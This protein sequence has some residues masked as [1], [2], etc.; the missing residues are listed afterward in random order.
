MAKIRCSRQLR[1][2]EARIG[3]K[4]MVGKASKNSAD[5]LSAEERIDARMAEL[6]DWRGAR[7]A[8]FRKLIH[9]AEPD[10]TEEWKW[11]GTPVWEYNGILLVGDG[12]KDK[13]KLTF[14]CGA[15]LRDANKVFNAGLGGNKWRA[16][17]SFEGD[18]IDKTGF[19][20]LVREA[21]SYNTKQRLSKA[22]GGMVDGKPVLL[23][24]GNPQM[25]KSEGDAPVQA[26]IAAIPRW[27]CDL[28]RRLD[29]IIVGNVPEV[30]KAMR[31]NSPFYGVEGR[32]WFVSYHVFSRYV[33]VTFLNGASLD[34]VP[35][36]DGKDPDAR[37][38]D[39][40]EGELDEEQMA[41]W[42]RQS[43][44]LPGWDGF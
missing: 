4:E 31:W 41:D 18:E 28:A 37:W 14:Q 7:L 29:E 35:S 6:D 2:S 19:K 12:F 3:V 9:E 40:Y 34:P 26:Y 24:G 36:G 8:E 11:R 5:E 38:V 10:V 33:K 13:V 42:V 39:I 22:N 44:G 23:S 16:I 32:G 20:K 15:M 21:V 1:E 27:E 17:D 43:A 30:R 25:P